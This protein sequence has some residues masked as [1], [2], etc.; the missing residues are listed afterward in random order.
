MCIY[1]SNTNTITPDIIRIKTYILY[2]VGQYNGS[3]SQK[4][5]ITCHKITIYS[6]L[7]TEESDREE[8]HQEYTDSPSSAIL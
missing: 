2:I 7:S 4:T 8:S 1:N 6:L 3:F 5:A